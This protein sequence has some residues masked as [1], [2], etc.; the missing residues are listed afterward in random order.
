MEP[1]NFSSSI[2]LSALGNIYLA[3]I[4]FWA[5]IHPETSRDFII[6]TAIL[7]C[8]I[9]FLTIHSSGMLSGSYPTLGD[10]EEWGGQTDIIFKWVKRFAFSWRFFLFCFYLI[11]VASL[12]FTFHNF[13]ALF[14]FVISLLS[15]VFARTPG[16]E[17][18][19]IAFHVGLFLLTMVIVSSLG[20]IFGGVHGGSLMTCN[21]SKCSGLFI[22]VPWT[23]LSWGILYYGALAIMEPYFSFHPGA[24]GAFLRGEFWSR[25][26]KQ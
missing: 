8:M 24:T 9:E 11:F 12:Y 19:H 21:G 14:Y 10:G 1:K 26:K 18:E 4:F 25:K 13:Y 7:I 17:S 15:K 16:E 22:E 6:N 20:G 23:I 3:G 2:W 5:L